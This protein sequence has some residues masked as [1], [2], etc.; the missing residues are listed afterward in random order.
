MG[1][2]PIWNQTTAISRKNRRMF[3][4]LATG[5]LISKYRN[6]EIR[7]LTLT[8][9]KTPKY[10][11]GKDGEIK[12]RT[13]KQSWA[14]LRKRIKRGNIAAENE[15]ERFRGFNLNK[16]YALRTEEGNGVYHIV[17]WG[18]NY[19]PYEWLSKTWEKIHGAWNISIEYVH[20]KKK[21]INGL[22]G[23]LLD[24]YLLNQPIKRMSYGWGW[25]WLGFCKSWENLKLVYCNMRKGKLTYD[26]EGKIVYDQWIYNGVTDKW[27]IGVKWKN[28]VSAKPVSAWKSI[29]GNHRVTSRQTKLIKYL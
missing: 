11:R 29:L 7:F 19:I 18:G 10:Y 5:A 21:T 27:Q 24:R 16:Y 26:K 15:K 12:E 28:K 13:I 17:F 22:V 3:H 9:S 23:Y 2:S 14:A 8:S 6:S 20:N 25:A 1:Y 4:R